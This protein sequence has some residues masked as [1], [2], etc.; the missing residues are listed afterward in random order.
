MV[1]AR[2]IAQRIARL[3]PLPEAIHRIDQCVAAVAPR[4]AAPAGAVG[5]ALASDRIVAAEALPARALALRD[6]WAVRSDAILDAGSY[7][8]AVLTEPPVAVDVGNSLPANTDAIIP[9]D[10]VEFAEATASAL[11]PA[12]PGEGVLLR[13]ADIF[14]GEALFHGGRRLS[15]LDLAVL[16][17][18][19]H[20]DISIREPRVHVVP[21]REGADTIIDAIGALLCRAI[22]AEGGVAIKDASPSGSAVEMALRDADADAVMIVGGSG[23]GDRDHSVETLARLGRV[24]FHG[25]GLTPGETAAF[26]LV[27]KRPVLVLPGR[28]DAALAVWLVLGRHM[29]ARLAARVGDDPDPAWPV[30]LARKI[31]STVGLA[32]VIVGRRDGG[33]A[34]P[35]ASG[36]L[37]LQALA[38][39]DGWILVPPDLEGVPADAM[40]LMKPLP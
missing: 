40:V 4:Q 23:A 13:G 6:G 36:Y 26:G 10:A 37:S 30:T 29:L 21:A 8:P 33:R 38:Q 1:A 22:E 2:P 16:M 25:V 32:E 7:A 39:A 31:T 34:V 3:V 14:G 35:L 18:S 17:A 15:R 19:G 20:G 11:H 24:E 5:R 9:L 27:D 12:S 28:L